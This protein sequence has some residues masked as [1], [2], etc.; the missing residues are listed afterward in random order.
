MENPSAVDPL[1]GRLASSRPS[2]TMAYR[3]AIGGFFF[4][5]LFLLAVAEQARW[6][7]GQ[8]EMTPA[9]AVLV[10]LLF[11]VPVLLHA[12]PIWE[13]RRASRLMADFAR[14]P[15][16]EGMVTALRAQRRY[17]KAAAICH[18]SLIVWVVLDFALIALLLW[19]ANLQSL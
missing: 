8:G 7:V 19:S 11:A 5:G 13:L 14:S 15:S 12:W 16:G 1:L 10:W 2:L 6:R 17:W 9:L 3:V 18:L 4:W